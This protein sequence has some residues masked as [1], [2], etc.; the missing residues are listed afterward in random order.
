MANL[1][2]KFIIAKIDDAN[3]Y[4]ST[5]E[6]LYLM[7]LI[8]KINEARE[9]EGKSNN[10]YVVCNLDEPYSEKVLETIINGENEKES[11]K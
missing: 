10:D 3:K 8:T 4:L 11:R 7:S 9:Q 6:Y 5:K 1:E 2:I